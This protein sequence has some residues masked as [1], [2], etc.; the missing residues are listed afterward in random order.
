MKRNGKV[1]K[2]TLGIVLSAAMLVSGMTFM[3]GSAVEVQAAA[4]TKDVNLGFGGISDPTSTES[5]ATAWTGS[6]VYYGDKLWRVLDDSGFLFSEDLLETKAYHD[7]LSGITWE[8]C[9]LRS[10]LNGQTFLNSNF[11]GTEQDAI[12]DTSVTNDSNPDYSTAGGNNTT[13]KLFLLSL[14]E[15]R[16]TDYGFGSDATR[17]ASSWWWLR[18]PGY[19][20]DRAADVDYDGYVYSNGGSVSN[21]NGSVRPAL[22]LNLSSVLFTSASGASKSSFGV[23]GDSNVS[24]NTW[25]LTL[26]GTEN[27]L[28]ANKTNGKTSL[29]AGYSAENLII[30]HSAATTLTDATQV[31]AMLT[32]S[33]GTVLYYGSVNSD[34]TATSSTVTIPAGLAVGTYSLYVIAEDVNTGNLTDYATALGTAISIN[35]NA[36]PST[37]A[38]T[39]NNGTG[40]GNYE[41]NATV[42]I[43]ADAAPSGQHFKEW[44]GADSLNFTSGSKTSTTATFTMPANAVTLTA[45]YENDT[46]PAPST[47][48][49]TVNNGT[50]DGNYEENATVT[51][52]ADAAPSGQ[53]FKEWTG[54]DSLNFTSGSKTSTTATFTMPANAVTLTAT[55]ENDTPPAPSTYAVTEVPTPTPP[56]TP[57]PTT[58]PEPTV[59]PTPSVTPVPA[60]E[61]TV[62]ITDEDIQV[63]IK[64]NSELIENSDEQLT[65]SISSKEILD[66]MDNE[67]LT[68][69][70]VGVNLP[71][72]T[73][74][75]KA[76]NIDLILE[77]ELIQ[78]AKENKKDIVVDVK[79]SDNNVLYSWSF[80]KN[81]LTNSDKD[82]TDVHLA[83]KIDKAPEEV[84][85]FS[86]EDDEEAVALV[87]DF[88]HEGVLP[89]Q[90]SVRIYVGDQEGVVPG[91]K[92]YLYHLNEDI[93]KLETIPY[94]YQA[95]VDEYG[96][97]TINIL[98]CSDYVVLTKEADS[99]HYL[100]LRQQITVTPKKITL[101][102]SKGIKKGKVNIELPIT[103]E[104][105]K[106]LEDP[107]SQSAIGGVTIKFSSSDKNIATVDS[108]GN[109]TAKAPGEAVIKVTM[110]LYSK[111]T[112]KVEIRVKVEP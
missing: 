85:Y 9:T 56:V 57:V 10:Y 29:T 20:D 101:S 55:Y 112:K 47:Y 53:H 7:T 111:K 8:N 28:G 58:T 23:V 89:S 62:N 42:T 95:I 64:L 83:L 26:E 92:V 34:T 18:S 80:D 103:L 38:V 68:A 88:A 2:K 78:K 75:N 54:A 61:I 39:V 104:W 24:N 19:Y 50:G 77:S 106:S 105:A 91:T 43:T 4:T 96:Y 40:D 70:R 6:K 35:V 100:S 98:Q 32:D 12:K 93:G 5:S 84:N 52:T 81:E 17:A 107:T 31:S 16:N 37:Y 59:T 15:V 46:P 86:K 108:K 13:D 60:P 69:V 110:T 30:S 67:E 33:Y 1:F 109:I 99:E 87:V 74:G 65:V 3:P 27:T 51:I 14:A 97:I 48:A 90:A 44:T 71:E 22:N 45:T 11:T 94:G 21:V 63:E 49:V 102:L 73:D 41:E 72:Q 79:D 76:D 36:A 66:E 25:K 82:L